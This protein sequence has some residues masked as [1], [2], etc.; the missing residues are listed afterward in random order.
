MISLWKNALE[1]LRCSLLGVSIVCQPSDSLVTQGQLFYLRFA[2]FSSLTSKTHTTIL[3]P[4]VLQKRWGVNESTKYQYD[5]ASPQDIEYHAYPDG[6]QFS[7]SAARVPA[8][9]CTH[10][11]FEEKRHGDCGI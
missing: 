6:L 10:P 11:V 2:G 3:F 7:W 4:G 9:V 1:D 5:F 8:S